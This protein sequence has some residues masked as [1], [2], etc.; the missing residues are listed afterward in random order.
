V[1]VGLRIANTRGPELEHNINKWAKIVVG[2]LKGGFIWTRN[3]TKEEH[4][5]RQILERD[6]QIE[7]Y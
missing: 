2:T 5:L 7:A 4:V 1:F 6:W 3:D